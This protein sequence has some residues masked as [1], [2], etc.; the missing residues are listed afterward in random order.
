VQITHMRDS[1]L[2][3]SGGRARV[4]CAEGFSNAIACEAIRNGSVIMIVFDRVLTYK[5]SSEQLEVV[6]EDD[7]CKSQYAQ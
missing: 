4:R 1:A 3:D 7:S 2:I 6:L 5:M